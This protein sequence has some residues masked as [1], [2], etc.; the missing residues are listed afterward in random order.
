MQQRDVYFEV[1]VVDDGSSD[2][3]VQCVVQVAGDF[4]IECSIDGAV[5]SSISSP[6]APS[7]SNQ[8]CVGVSILRLGSRRGL[9]SALESGLRVAKA[10]C[11]ARMDADDVCLPNRLYLQHEFLLRHPDII[12]VGGQALSI[13]E[14][15]EVLS[16]RSLSHPPPTPELLHGVPTHPCVVA[17]ELGS[18]CCVL[19]PTAMYRRSIVLDE[20]GGYRGAA[21]LVCKALD[22]CAD[23]VAASADDVAVAEDY[24][25]WAAI[26]IRFLA[27]V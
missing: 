3:S 20:F 26:S 15:Y 19:H 11:I 9:V 1:I 16:T 7:S 14:D 18:R 13:G 24:A 6:G 2:D 10:E 12:V 4:G 17:F 23:A 27:S 5:A 22:D 21:E 25:L 8:W